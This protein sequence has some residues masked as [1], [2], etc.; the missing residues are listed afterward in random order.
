MYLCFFY[1]CLCFCFLDKQSKSKNRTAGRRRAFLEVCSCLGS[2]ASSRNPPPPRNSCRENS[3]SCSP[4]M[5]NCLVSPL[6]FYC[7][8]AVLYGVLYSQPIPILA[9]PC[10]SYNNSFFLHSLCRDRTTYCKLQCSSRVETDILFLIYSLP[11]RVYSTPPYLLYGG[12]P[13]RARV[14]ECEWVWARMCFS[15]SSFPPLQNQTK[16]KETRRLLFFL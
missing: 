7:R 4:V 9:L 15:L 1:F 8:V 3:R 16:R 10:F 12:L 5:R 2:E 11:L 6:H 13:V 14:C